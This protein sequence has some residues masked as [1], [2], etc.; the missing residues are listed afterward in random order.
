MVLSLISP[1]NWDL[2]KLFRKEWEWRNA[3]KF[4]WRSGKIVLGNLDP[5]A[6][7]YSAGACTE[8]RFPSPNS[9]LS[10]AAL[11][12]NRNTL[13]SLFCPDTYPSDEALQNSG[14]FPWK[15]SLSSHW[16][17]TC[18][19]IHDQFLSETLAF[20]WAWPVPVR[21]FQGGRIWSTGSVP[22]GQGF[23]SA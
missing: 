6:C 22:G 16:H 17:V 18:W 19:K 21:C 13:P 23:V 5:L 9:V 11:W 7:T 3:I 8:P 12:K 4:S 20:P 2:L 10:S 15:D 1:W 14:I